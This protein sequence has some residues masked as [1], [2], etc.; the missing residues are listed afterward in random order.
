[1]KT[2]RIEC[3]V[4]NLNQKGYMVLNGDDTC[5]IF[6]D[7]KLPKSERTRVKK[8]FESLL[9]LLEKHLAH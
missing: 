3:F 1:M 8:D 5:F 9:N 6:I 7:S 4:K 2:P